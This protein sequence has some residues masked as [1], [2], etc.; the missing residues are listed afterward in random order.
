MWEN[1]VL[2]DGTLGFYRLWLFITG[3]LS[4]TGGRWWEAVLGDS[5][6]SLTVPPCWC[7]EPCSAAFSLWLVDAG[8]LCLGETLESPAVWCWQCPEVGLVKLAC[9]CSSCFWL[10][11]LAALECAFTGSP[12]PFLGQLDCAQG[13]LHRQGSCVRC[14]S[15]TPAWH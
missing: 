7:W 6:Q 5:V 11:F 8:T 9:S 4:V 13:W 3:L 2:A 12:H 15:P 10:V 14:L 1:P